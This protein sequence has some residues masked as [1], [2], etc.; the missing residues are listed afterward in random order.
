MHMMDVPCGQ[1]TSEGM[2]SKLFVNSSVS[3]ICVNQSSAENITQV[4]ERCTYT[5]ADDSNPLQNIDMC[6]PPYFIF[7]SKLVVLQPSRTTCSP[8]TSL[9]L[10]SLLSPPLGVGPT[11]T[12]TPGIYIMDQ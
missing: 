8:S 5:Q 6:Q 12:P 10:K 11:V 7:K 1:F 2:I 3:L 4:I 9:P